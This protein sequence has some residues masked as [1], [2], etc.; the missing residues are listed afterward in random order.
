MLYSREQYR[1]VAEALDFLEAKRLLPAYLV[2]RCSGGYLA[3][4]AAVR[5]ARCDGLVTVN[6]Y[7]FH[8]DES[9]SVDEA[10]RFA[11]RSLETYGRKLLQMETLKRLLGGKIDA[12]NA[13]LNMA[14]GLG[15]RGM[16]TSRRLLGA[17]PFFAAA[18]GPVLGGFRTLAKRGVDMSLIYSAHDIGLDHLHD[19]FGENGAGLKH[20]PDI[21]LTIIP[22]ADHNLSPPYARKVYL[23]E[24]REMGLRLGKPVTP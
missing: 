7:S 2:G 17:F 16:R 13:M 3:F 10:L 1:D 6:P 19:Q 14:A 21:R 9:Q 11:P 22:E 5:D 20:F 8:W 23:R 12:K 18:Q 24:V 15:R 4:Q